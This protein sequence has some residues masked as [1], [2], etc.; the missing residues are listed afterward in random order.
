[1]I[2]EI[3]RINP[4]LFVFTIPQVFQL[5]CETTNNWVLIKL[6][7]LLTE[8]CGAEPRLLNK[9]VPKFKSLLDSQKAKSVQYEVVRSILVL[10]KQKAEEPKTQTS[11]AS[12]D[13]YDLAVKILI[14]EFVEQP[15]PNLRLLGLQALE[16]IIDKKTR[17]VFAPRILQKFQNEKEYSI[18]NYLARLLKKIIDR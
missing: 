2:Y 5:L 3:S 10:C 13:L 18:I 17:I 12:A 11:N 4:S 16:S 6:I 1:M 15:D 14:Q 7:K 8:L 9:L